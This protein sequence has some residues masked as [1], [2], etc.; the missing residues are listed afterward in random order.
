MEMLGH[1]CYN[2]RERERE[3][4]DKKYNYNVIR[5]SKIRRPET[6]QRK[7]SILNVDYYSKKQIVD[8]C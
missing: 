8:D 4:A 5:N 2:N 1:A 3:R 6:Q 7:Q